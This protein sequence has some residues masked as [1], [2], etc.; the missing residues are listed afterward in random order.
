M[1]KLV[2]RAVDFEERGGTRAQESRDSLAGPRF[3][4]VGP[5]IETFEFEA[6]SPGRDVIPGLK[7]AMRMEE[8]AIDLYGEI[9]GGPGEWEQEFL[10]AFSRRN[11]STWRLPR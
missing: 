6:G 11:G 10:L 2:Q 3:S 8:E 1:E 4:A 5:P 7:T 9:L